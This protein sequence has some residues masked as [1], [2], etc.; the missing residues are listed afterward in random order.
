MFS[1]IPAPLWWLP[2]MLSF[3]FSLFLCPSIFFKLQK[4]QKL[5]VYSENVHTESV[6]LSNLPCQHLLLFYLH[7][8]HRSLLLVKQCQA[9]NSMM[10][11]YFIQKCLIYKKN[12][13]HNSSAKTLWWIG[14]SQAKESTFLN[15][16]ALTSS[17]LKD[18]YTHCPTLYHLFP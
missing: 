7:R 18:F 12:Y 15:G 9:C 1:W 10:K 5:Y 17:L 2:L 3:T 6:L 13:G 11:E 14:V 8:S 4:E 16:A